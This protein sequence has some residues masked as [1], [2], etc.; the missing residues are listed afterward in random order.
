MLHSYPCS[1]TSQV[2]VA[3]T[4]AHN[5]SPAA[6]D[7]LCEELLDHTFDCDACINGLENTCPVFC[8]LQSRIADAGGVTRG[9]ALAI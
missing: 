7:A 9:I 5:C 2:T 3:M 4:H 8:S 1:Q 6:P